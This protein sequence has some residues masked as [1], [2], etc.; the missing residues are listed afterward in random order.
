MSNFKY[1]LRIW[2]MRGESKAKRHEGDIELLSYSF[3]NPAR[4]SHHSSGGTGSPRRES[5]Q[6]GNWTATPGKEVGF[7]EVVKRLDK[8]T[9]ELTSAAASGRHYD[10]VILFIE[11]T[12]VNAVDMPVGA[13]I[14]QNAM[15]EDMRNGGYDD[16]ANVFLDVV[17]FSAAEVLS[18]YSP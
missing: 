15:V 1:Y 3:Y 8:T 11:R 10:E 7:F 18:K 17:R 16:K 13:Y 12:A 9:A 2:G 14:F 4:D 6:V 5:K